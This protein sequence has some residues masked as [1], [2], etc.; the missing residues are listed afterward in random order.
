MVLV[1][2]NERCRDMSSAGWH[3]RLSRQSVPAGW[4]KRW[5]WQGGGMRPPKLIYQPL[6]SIQ[7]SAASAASSFALLRFLPSYQKRALMSVP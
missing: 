2:E 5:M 7:I 1:L 6:C 3:C 4:G